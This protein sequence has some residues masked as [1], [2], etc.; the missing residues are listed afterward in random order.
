MRTDGVVEGRRYRGGN[1]LL[2]KVVVGL[3]TRKKLS[4]EAKEEGC[5]QEQR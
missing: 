1:G 3:V 5:P 4:A 2:E